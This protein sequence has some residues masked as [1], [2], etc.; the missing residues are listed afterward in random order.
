MER[1]V[2]NGKSPLYNRAL[3][4]LR[5][6]PLPFCVT[7][8]FFPGY[9]AEE[10]VTIYGCIGGVPLYME[11]LDPLLAFDDN[12]ARLLGAN[13]ILDDAGALLR[14]QLAEPRNYTAIVESIASGFTR[15]GDIARM[16]GLAESAAGKYLGVLQRLGIVARAVPATVSRPEESKQGHYR[17]VD[18]YLRFYF[19]FIQQQRGAIERGHLVQ[20]WQN[21]RQHLSEFVGKHA[22]EELCREWVEARA[23][24]GQLGFVPRRVGAWWERKGREIDV[25]AVNEDEHTIL[26]GECK[27]TNEPLGERVVRELIRDKQ[28]LLKLDVSWKVRY[29]F[30]SRSGFTAEAIMAA[31][32]APCE[33][34]N[35]QRLDS[36]LAE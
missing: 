7:K 8:D 23:D 24:Q 36:E 10:R 18:S 1:E 12:M 22:Y 6:G 31:G 21:M 16:S 15:L 13:V 14:D 33:W 11:L 19:R 5:L 4:G 32:G 3:D 35:L 20:A 2:L 25:C 26:L 27:W 30:F 28:P 9:T 34:V 29:A 17:V